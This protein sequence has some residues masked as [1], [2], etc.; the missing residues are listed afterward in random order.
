MT[1]ISAEEITATF[2]E[3]S[4]ALAP[5]VSRPSDN[6]IQSIVE[7]LAGVPVPILFD[8]TNGNTDSL[9]ALVTTDL[10]Y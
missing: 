9:L 10:E 5:C 6:Y 3:A 8:I 7:T 1:S 2:A 4:K